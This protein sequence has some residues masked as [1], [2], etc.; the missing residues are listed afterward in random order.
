MEFSWWL[1]L[2]AGFAGWLIGYEKLRHSFS[3]LTRIFTGSG[4]TDLSSLLPDHDDQVERDL[5]LN[6]LLEQYAVDE[7][8]VDVYLTLGDAFR[9]RGEYSLS[10]IHI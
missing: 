8:S 3:S 10:L 1:V 9:R 2:L 7:N 4:R 5:E 6:N